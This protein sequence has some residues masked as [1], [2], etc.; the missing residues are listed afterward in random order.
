[1]AYIP[2]NIN[3]QAAMA[4]SAPV[5][6]AT[7]QTNVPIA[8]N[9]LIFPAST[10]NSSVAQLAASAIFVGALENTQNLQAA[11]L[12]VFSDQPYTVFIEQFIDAAGTKLSAQDSFT[13]LANVPY[14]EN[15][16]IPGNYFRVRVQNTGASATTT[17]QIDTTFGI[18]GSVTTTVGS[19]YASATSIEISL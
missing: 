13:R 7:N 5:V 1:M 12:E 11:Q 19:G 16:T 17:L 4:N 10:N 14:S 3:G 6:I 9:S 8:I 2:P 15:I 18:N